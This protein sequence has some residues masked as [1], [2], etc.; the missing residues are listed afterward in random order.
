[1]K[2]GQPLKVIV[3]TTSRSTTM[4]PK[5]EID[6]IK[7]SKPSTRRLSNIV[8]IIGMDYASPRRK[9]PIHN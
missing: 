7:K 5:N 6:D 4:I 8:D 2:T 1:M 3:E 9:P